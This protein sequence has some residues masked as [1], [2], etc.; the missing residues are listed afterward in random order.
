MT[1]LIIILHLASGASV[2]KGTSAIG[3]SDVSAQTISAARL[4]SLVP[5]DTTAKEWILRP[6]PNKLV[7]EYNTAT[8]NPEKLG[9]VKNLFKLAVFS[10]MCREAMTIMQKSDE[11]PAVT[12]K[13]ITK[14]V[15]IKVY[16]MMRQ[17]F[18]DSLTSLDEVVSTFLSSPPPPPLIPLQ[19]ESPPPGPPSASG[20]NKDVLAVDPSLLTVLE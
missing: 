4:T 3:D 19:H 17:I 10:V 6:D 1:R 5:G 12:D 7:Q 13:A 14:R 20:S 16:G 8:E 18:P 15:L 11:C 9:Q 2:E